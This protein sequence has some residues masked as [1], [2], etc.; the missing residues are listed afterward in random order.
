MPKDE[1]VLTL[2]A[3][4]LVQLATALA[5]LVLGNALMAAV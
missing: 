2:V 5:W 1:L 3:M 4:T